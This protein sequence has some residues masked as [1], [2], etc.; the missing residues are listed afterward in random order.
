MMRL[1]LEGVF[2]VVDP[3]WLKF[4]E[5]PDNLWHKHLDKEI[6]RVIAEI[7]S[8]AIN[9]EIS[10]TEAGHLLQ[11]ACPQFF[12]DAAYD[13]IHTEAAN[14][15][16]QVELASYH[17]AGIAMKRWRTSK[18]DRVCEDCKRMEGEEVSVDEKFSGGVQAPPLHE[19]CRCFL[20][21]VESGLWKIDGK[22]IR[23]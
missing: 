2:G 16:N 12:G 21:A 4:L 18:D 22:V 13:I 17:K 19:G 20:Q 15:C 10:I 14:A 23:V 1:D 7:A 5:N 9:N 6:R 8:R 3:A 11:E